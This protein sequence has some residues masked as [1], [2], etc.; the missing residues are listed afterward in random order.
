MVAENIGYGW[1]DAR[2][3]ALDLNRSMFAEQP[4]NDGHRRNI[5]SNANVV[6][7]DVIVDTQNSKVW[8]TE[9]FARI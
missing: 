5:L 9:D 6:G 3:A 4:P 8:L 7:I 1:G 2:Q